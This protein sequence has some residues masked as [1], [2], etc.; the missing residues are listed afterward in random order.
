MIADSIKMKRELKVWKWSDK[1][2]NGESEKK[3]SYG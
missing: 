1:Q 2:G 3:C